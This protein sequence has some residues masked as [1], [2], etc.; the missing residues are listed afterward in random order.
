MGRRYSSNKLLGIAIS[1]LASTVSTYTL[2]GWHR[3]EVSAYSHGCIMPRSGKE[4]NH[5]HRGANGQWP[6]PNLTIAAD[7]SIPFGTVMELSYDG[8]ITKREVGDRGEAIKGNRIDL[9]V[10][11]CAK[12]RQF[13][14]KIIYGKVVA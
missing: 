1:L 2:N 12:A 9:F 6:I 13:G 14:R 10:E 3:Y 11:T 8:I 5:K 7:P 4:S